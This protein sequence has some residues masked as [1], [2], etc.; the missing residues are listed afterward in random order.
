MTGGGKGSSWLVGR[1][2][3]RANGP[4]QSEEC[5][6]RAVQGVFIILLSSDITLEAKAGFVA[7]LSVSKLGKVPVLRIYQQ[8]EKA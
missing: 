1:A 6:G 4:G 5:L 2:N 3:G 8:K 7:M